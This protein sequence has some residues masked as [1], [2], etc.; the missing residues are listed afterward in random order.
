MRHLT[1][2]TIDLPDTIIDLINEY[3][4]ETL[5][6]IQENWMIALAIAFFAIITLILL[7]KAF[8]KSPPSTPDQHQA[9]IDE[10]I[11]T[12]DAEMD[13]L[14]GE[15]AEKTKEKKRVGKPK[16]FS[17]V[18][19]GSLITMGASNLGIDVGGWM[20]SVPELITS[21]IGG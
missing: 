3:I 20:S 7:S 21:L 13:A 10:M 9:K 8:K 18:A 15:L 16:G 5:P 17:L 14:K 4:P 11:T 2:N 1:M 6:W 12:H 19:V